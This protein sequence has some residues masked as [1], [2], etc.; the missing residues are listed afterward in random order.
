MRED[1]NL[2]M[3]RRFPMELV[4]WSLVR[5]MGACSCEKKIALTIRS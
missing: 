5:A 4:R 3:P 2:E 1:S